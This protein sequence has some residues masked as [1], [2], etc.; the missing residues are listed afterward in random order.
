M[1]NYVTKSYTNSSIIAVA[2]HGY[3]IDHI[4][5]ILSIAQKHNR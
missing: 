5:A 4:V 3:N 1:A 2:I